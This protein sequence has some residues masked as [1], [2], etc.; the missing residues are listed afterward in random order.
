MMKLRIDSDNMDEKDL[1]NAVKTE[2]LDYT[3][4]KIQSIFFYAKKVLEKQKQALT[5]EDQHS[6]LQVK[7]SKDF[8]YLTIIQIIVIVLIGA[9]HLYSFRKYL[10]ANNII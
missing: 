1:Q 6:D 3:N 8:L 9:Y 5:S 2:D 10:L 7:F 4:Q